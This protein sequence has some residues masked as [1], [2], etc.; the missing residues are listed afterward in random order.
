MP[1]I[2]RVCDL[3]L[4]GQQVAAVR[5]STGTAEILK[6]QQCT[7]MLGTSSWYMAMSS[8]PGLP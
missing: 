2:S 4:K 1:E 6:D 7:K 8:G 5:L 3:G